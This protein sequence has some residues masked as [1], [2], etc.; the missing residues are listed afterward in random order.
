MP[1]CRHTRS[2]K[3]MRWVAPGCQSEL[4]PGG[5]ADSRWSIDSPRSCTQG[6]I[7]SPR[8]RLASSISNSAGCD[9]MSDVPGLGLLLDTFRH[10]RCGLKMPD[11][12]RYVGGP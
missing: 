3:A 5:G 11:L 10:G 1:P 4:A 8:T 7:T 12:A 9:C 2:E 6:A